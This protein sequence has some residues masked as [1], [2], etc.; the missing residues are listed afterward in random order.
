MQVCGRAQTN[1]GARPA[2]GNGKG[3]APAARTDPV[4]V[5]PACKGVSDRERHVVNVF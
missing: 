5:L 1:P 3:Y 2:H 4:E